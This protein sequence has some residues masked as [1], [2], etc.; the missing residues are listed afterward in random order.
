MTYTE[1]YKHLK[2]TASIRGFRKGKAPNSI[3]AREYGPQ[4]RGEV[5][6][7][8][9]QQTITD[10]IRQADVVMVLEPQLEEVSDVPV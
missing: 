5:L 4:I 10:A 3:L 1:V 6:E 9:I 2:K 7:K 8:L